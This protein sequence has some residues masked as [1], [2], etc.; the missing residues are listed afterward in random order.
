MQDNMENIEQKTYRAVTLDKGKKVLPLL[1]FSIG[2]VLMLLQWIIGLNLIVLIGAIYMIISS[3]LISLGVIVKR[4]LY[5]WYLIGY[6]AVS[7]GIATYFIFNG[8]DAG[9]GA[10]V[11]DG[12]TGFISSEHP[13]WQGEGNFWTRLAG[14]IVICGPAFL[15]LLT[16]YLIVDKAK[17]S[18]KLKTGITSAVSVV[19]VGMSVLF[20]FTTNL[21]SNP[22]VFDMSK[23]HDEYLDNVNKNEN[24]PNVLVILMDDLGYGDTSYNARKA[25]MTPA[26]ETPNIDSIALNGTDFDNFYSSYS[27]CSPARFALM[28]GRYPYRGYADNVMYPT[29]NSFSP[30]ATTRVFNSIELGANV[31]GMLGDEV[32]IAETFQ[33]A[34]YSTGCFGKWHL[35][36]YGQYL[37]TNQGFDYFYGSHHVN[38]MTPFYHSVEKDGSYEIVQGT[39]KLD[40]SNATG[41]IHSEISSWIENEI[42]EGNQF[43]A[44]YATPWPHAPV[45]AGYDYQ[46]STGA[47]IYADC[48][49]EFDDYLG[50]LFEMLETKGVLDDTIIVFTSDNGP[51][52]QGSTNELRGGKYSAYNAGQKLPFY[53]RWDGDTEG[54]FNSG[55]PGVAKTVEQIATLADLYPTLVE[56]CGITGKVGDNP[57]K[58]V[59]LP[60]DVDRYIDGVSMMPLLEDDTNTVYIH[61]QD[62]PIL[63]MKRE[64]VEAIQYTVTKDHVLESVV[65]YTS[66]TDHA[67]Q[68]GN[69]ADYAEMPFIRDNELLTWKY[70]KSYKNDNPEF[71]DKTRKN[72]FMCLT[73]D[74]SE[75]YQRADVFPDLCKEYA[76]TLEQVKKNLKENRRA[77]KTEYYNN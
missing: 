2:V 43:F 17:W 44:Y 77:I 40:Q 11:G 45:Y 6:V 23:G 59:Y 13:L 47:G 46:G 12:K 15:L 35:G 18:G 62:N 28:T 24:G 52:L 58:E 73:D 3:V 68:T 56:A 48:V 72:W 76:D 26:F 25:G 22:R 70:I 49:T 7:F 60:S 16:M 9:W 29:V 19:L 41:L 57:A 10:L 38:D 5:L 33:A 34:G 30:L 20:V 61:G 69:E 66:T 36:D 31:D 74:T 37:P 42:D 55:T 67:I 50:K 75:S 64:Q 8:A 53:I 54:R 63:H 39:E 21:R 1:M 32:T 65:G 4:K 14:N 27:V 71:F 51:A